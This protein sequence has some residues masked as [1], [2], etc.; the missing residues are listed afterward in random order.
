V[1]FPQPDQVLVELHQVNE[2]TSILQWTRNALGEALE[3]QDGHGVNA[4]TMLDAGG[5]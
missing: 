2:I 5:G 4:S 3:N 1:S